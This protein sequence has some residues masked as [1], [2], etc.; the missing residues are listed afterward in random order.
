MVSCT[1]NKDVVP[2]EKCMFCDF[3][4]GTFVEENR[5]ITLCAFSS[6]QK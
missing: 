6:V 4:K 1:L 3:C 5:T 2:V